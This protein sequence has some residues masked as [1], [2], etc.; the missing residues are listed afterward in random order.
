[1]KWLTAW[2]LLWL[3]ILATPAHANFCKSVTTERAR[4]EAR[5]LEKE[6]FAAGSVDYVGDRVY[7][8]DIISCNRKRDSNGNEVEKA[9][10]GNH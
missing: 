6:R 7:N 8:A 4:D 5:L 1:M 3:S 9:I 10:V 2:S